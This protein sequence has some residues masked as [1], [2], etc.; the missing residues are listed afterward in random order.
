MQDF[1][2]SLAVVLIA[3]IIFIPAVS[4]AGDDAATLY[5]TKC[6][7]CHGADGLA[8]TPM[9]KKQS[10]PSFASD[11][12]QKSSPADIQDFV[13]NG[14]KEKK[15]SHAFG[16]KGVTNDDAK[17]LAILVRDLGKKK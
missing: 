11:K 16:G 14:G 5:K 10:I 1:R 8:N 13:L 15:A 17:K 12:I 4:W 6:A 9:G 3:L 7:V 2:F